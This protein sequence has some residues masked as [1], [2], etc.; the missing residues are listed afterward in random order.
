MKTIHLSTLLLILSC[1]SLFVGVNDLSISGIIMNEGNAQALL[2]NSRI[3]RL[4]AIL[5]AG[6]GLSLAGLVMQQISQN[7]FAAPS[8]SGTIECAMLGY[9]LSL[10]I[11]GD[12]N[13]L[14][15]PF[16]FG[17]IGTFIFIKLIESVQFK[18][19]VFVPLIGIIWGNIVG[20]LVTFIAYKYDVLQSLYFL[21][22]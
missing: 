4:L 3:P 11:F 2:F 16:G 15:L 6:S 8:T 17:I 10:L 21:E 9:V 5:L 13:S 22:S 18:N 20:S 19:A 14:W 1:T 7:K 12:G